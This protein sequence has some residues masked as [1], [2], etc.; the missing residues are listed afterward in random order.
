[1]IDRDG[2][3]AGF[4]LL[5]TIDRDGIRRGEIVEC[6]LSDDDPRL[7]HGVLGCLSTQLQ[8][9][10]CDLVRCLGT[11]PWIRTALTQNGFFRR[12]RGQFLLRDPRGRLSPEGQF[13]LSGLEGDLAY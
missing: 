9:I 8:S 13:L 1:L 6:F 2:R 7:W 11:V 4:A 3:L 5:S 12:G 10:G